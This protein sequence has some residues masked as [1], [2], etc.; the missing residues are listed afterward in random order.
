MKQDTSVKEP[1]RPNRLARA[2]V[3][4]ALE[5]LR[6]D[7]VCPGDRLTEQGLATA[8][9]VSRTPVRALLRELARLGIAA[10]RHG[11][12]YVLRKLAPPA[13]MSMPEQP[14]QVDA[15]CLRIGRDRVA[16]T[17]PGAVSEADLMRR[18]GCSRSLT[19]RALERLAEVALAERKH[20]HGWFLPKIAFDSRARQESY[21]FRLLTEPAGILSPDFALPP[22]WIDSMRRQHEAILSIPWTET[23]AIPLFEMNSA[24][25]EGIAAASGNRFFL[26]AQQQQTRLRRFGNYDWPWGHQRVVDSCSQH[27]EI[28]EQLAR[29]A[30]EVA[31]ALMRRHLEQA[32]TLQRPSP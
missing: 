6:R 18:Y 21:A 10:P 11:G 1:H 19:V 14:D 27:L 15:L 8:L 28:L 30:H 24:F 25:H 7:G 16:D 9:R 17:L 26:L 4:R 2:L 29:D 5:V 31:A 3:P 32:R 12:G 20:G 22:G 13:Q 23:L